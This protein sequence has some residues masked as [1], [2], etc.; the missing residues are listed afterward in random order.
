MSKHEK[1]LKR[2]LSKPKDFTYNELMTL[3]SGLGYSEC[4]GGSTSGS[5]VAFINN[6][7][8]HIIRLHKP[9]PHNILKSYQ[10][11]LIEEELRNIEVIS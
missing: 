6:K 7:N 3:L 8:Q 11:E 1:L 4:T 9:H 10:I 2:F 5:R